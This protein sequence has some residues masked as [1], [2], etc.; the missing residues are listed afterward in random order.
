M[1]DLA[2]LHSL[3]TRYAELAEWAKQL[4]EYELV[5]RYRSNLDGYGY[6]AHWFIETPDPEAFEFER[7]VLR[8]SCSLAYRGDTE[9]EGVDLPLARLMDDAYLAERKAKAEEVLNVWRDDQAARAERGRQRDEV[10]ERAEYERLKA[11]YGG[12]G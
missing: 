10:A 8:V 7:G 3:V 12:A 2:T 6:P 5:I 1:T 9:Y 11:K 4:A